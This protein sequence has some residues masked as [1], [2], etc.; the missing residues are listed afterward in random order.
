MIGGQPAYGSYRTLI[1]YYLPGERQGREVAAVRQV[2]DAE[3]TVASLPDGQ[4]SLRLGLKLLIAPD[5]TVSDCR[6][7]DDLQIA[8]VR[9][10]CDQIVQ[11]KFAALSDANGTPVQ[12]VRGFSVEF[13][14]AK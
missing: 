2:A 1:A 14:L 4:N 11:V 3:F 10:A 7:S 9:A 6:G 8:F 13:S 12:H 5:G